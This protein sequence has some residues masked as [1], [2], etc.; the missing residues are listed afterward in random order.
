MEL[1]ATSEAAYENVAERAKRFKGYE[2]L[3]AMPV[4]QALCAGLS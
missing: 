4:S 1:L 2:E 3:F